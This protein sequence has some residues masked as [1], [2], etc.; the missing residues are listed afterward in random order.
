MKQRLEKLGVFQQGTLAVEEIPFSSAVTEACKANRCGKYATCWTCP[1]GLDPEAAKQQIR[2]YTTAWVFTCKYDL[3][4]PFDY[5][6]MVAGGKTT[7]K[8]LLKLTEELRAEGVE[9]MALGCEACILCEKCTYPDAPCRF[10]EQAIPSVEAC[11]VNVVT[12][13]KR[14]GVR[15]NNGPQTVTNFCVILENGG[16]E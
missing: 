14:V 10:P 5:E 6:T 4:D 15:Y 11:G 16:K 8:K 7:H 3:E 2:R 9:H 13:A 12:L 1:P